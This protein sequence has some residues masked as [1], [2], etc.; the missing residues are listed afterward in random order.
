[1]DSVGGVGVGVV[2]NDRKTSFRKCT[3]LSEMRAKEV[4]MSNKTLMTFS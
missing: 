1:M 3:S 2:L 4:A